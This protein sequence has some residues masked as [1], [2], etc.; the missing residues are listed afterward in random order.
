MRK[1]QS[2]HR[3]PLFRVRTV[4]TVIVKDKEG[5]VWNECVLDPGM[6]RFHQSGLT[7]HIV[8]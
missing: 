3:D 4:L 2:E 6:S 1:L 7:N 8:G 5:A